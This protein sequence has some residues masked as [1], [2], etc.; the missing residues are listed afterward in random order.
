MGLGLG[1]GLGLG[2]RVKDALDAG[3]EPVAAS[4]VI[5]AW[6]IRIRILLEVRVRVRVGL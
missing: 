1:L 4:V 6:L 5:R 2:A 3:E